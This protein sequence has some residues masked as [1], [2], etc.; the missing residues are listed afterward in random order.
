MG[1]Q[2]EIIK[3]Q[4]GNSHVIFDKSGLCDDSQMGDNFQDFEVLRVLGGGK[5]FV[6]KVRSLK[7]NKIYA[8]KKIDLSQ[9]KNEEEKKLCLA[10]MEKL[11]SLIH[12]HLIRYYK[13]FKD[14]NDCLY[15]IYEYMNNGDIQSFIKAHQVLEKKIKEEEI[16]NILL[17]CLSALEYLHKENLAHLAIKYTNIYLNNEQNVKVGLFRE[18]PILEDKDYNIKDDIMEIGLYFYKMCYSQFP[19]T[20]FKVVRGKKDYT[21]NN[22]DFPVKKEPNNYYSPELINIVLKMIEE[23]P[24]KR[25]SSGEL[26]NIVKD[27]YVKKFANNTSIKSVLRCLYSYPTF[28]QQIMKDEQNII[29]N[30]D[31]YYINY[32]Y[33]STIKAFSTN[34][35]LN[36]C[37]EEFRRALASENTKLDCS[38]EIDPI[39]L[40]AFLLE[41]MHREYNKVVQTQIKGIDY[42]QQYVINSRYKVEEEDKTNKEQMI[43][44]FNSYFNKNINSIISKLFFGVMKTK[45]ICRVCKSP[46]YSFSN[47]CFMAFDV[48]KCKAPIFDINQHGYLAQHKEKRDLVKEKYHVFCDKCLTE[49]N[50]NEFNRFY[51]F[52][53][54]LIICFFRGNNYNKNT[55][56]NVEEN[57]IIKKE[58][59]NKKTGEIERLYPEDKNSPFNYYLVGSVNR[60]TTKVNNEEK[61]VFHYFSRDPFNRTKW[62]S[63]LDNKFEILQQA[64]VQAIQQTGQVIILFYNAIKN[65]N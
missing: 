32:W 14:E 30:K 1:S 22:H 55:P 61:E 29:Q 15:L 58:R 54:H 21:A 57:L 8:M 20:I 18:T 41:K 3:D 16:W 63:S 50:H 24:N 35:D 10:Q 59:N 48:N 33:L 26:Y 62:Y 52:G 43:Q 6:S 5:N 46:A 37:L 19:E 31:K 60:V 12:P 51:S 45:K 39:Y 53:E 34:Q 38:K 56:I 17:Q 23:D 7:N 11:K 65:A 28:T 9:I 27:E 2:L 47:N 40:L 49:Q 4:E 42:S 25:L 44:K 64:P 36:K 13:T